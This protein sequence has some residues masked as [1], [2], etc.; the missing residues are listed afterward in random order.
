MYFSKQSMVSHQTNNTNVWPKSGWQIH[1]HDEHDMIIEYRYLFPIHI[2][3]L[4]RP[5]PKQAKYLQI[6]FWTTKNQ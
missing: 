4:P 6:L 3:I 2:T 5:S 1:E